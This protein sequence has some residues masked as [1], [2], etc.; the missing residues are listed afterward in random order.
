MQSWLPRHVILGVFGALAAL[1]ACLDLEPVQ[2]SALAYDANTLT[3]DAAP[4]A[5]SCASCI[6]SGACAD[7]LTACA[8]DVKC[9]PMV[10]CVSRL[11]CFE[12]HTQEDAYECSVPCAFS[13]GIFSSEEIGVQLSLAVG[14][15]GERECPGDC[16]YTTDG[17]PRSM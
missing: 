9:A 11:G 5:G 14:G 16:Y 7:E 15:C 10:E 12:L 8:A 17:L 6:Q 4:P 2:G 3:A 13:A 1:H